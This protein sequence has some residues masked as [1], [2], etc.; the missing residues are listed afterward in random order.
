MLQNSSFKNY[1][2]NDIL[3]VVENC[4]K[5][6]FFIER[7]VNKETG[8]EELFIKANQGHSMEKLE[9]DLIEITENNC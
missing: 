3:R 5:K 2:I 1:N 6:R 7:I 9:L 8:I 4:P